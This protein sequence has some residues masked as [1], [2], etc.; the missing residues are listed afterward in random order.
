MKR[1][2]ILVLWILLATGLVVI[3]AGYFLHSLSQWKTYTNTLEGYSIKYPSAWAFIEDVPHSGSVS[4]KL[5]QITSTDGKSFKI[6]TDWFY[7][8]YQEQYKDLSSLDKLKKYV[9][10]CKNV[11]CSPLPPSEVKEVTLGNIPAIE[12]VWNFSQVKYPEVVYFV[13]LKNETLVIKLDSKNGNPANDP[14]LQQIITSF[15]L[16]GPKTS[17]QNW[18]SCDQWDYKLFPVYPDSYKFAQPDGPNPRGSTGA[19]G[20]KNYLFVCDL[21]L[22]TKSTWPEVYSWY[23]N[24]WANNGFHAC[25]YDDPRFHSGDSG[26][27]VFKHA[28]FL[29]Q[30]SDGYLLAAI[31]L[32]EGGPNYTGNY[33]S[34]YFPGRENMFVRVQKQ[35]T[36]P[37]CDQAINGAVATSGLQ[38]SVKPQSELPK[39][40]LYNPQPQK[41]SNNWT[42]LIPKVSFDTFLSNLRSFAKNIP[43]IGWFL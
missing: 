31:D 37:I 2:N 13:D 1:G 35:I 22:A 41:G 8:F 9:E 36:L 6:E 27:S 29:R 32:Y 21:I 20:N 40:P 23:N 38:T 16:L 3:V 11:N 14:T 4:G 25:P 42:D 28:S 17:S 18:T 10:E 15:S 24:F 5:V 26:P 34:S 19:T 30:E 43:V 7:P 12:S 39:F 33:G